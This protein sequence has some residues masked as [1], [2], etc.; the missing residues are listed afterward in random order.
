MTSVCKERG[1]G[2]VE[3]DYLDFKNLHGSL[4]S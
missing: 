2:A 3:I 4:L 1:K